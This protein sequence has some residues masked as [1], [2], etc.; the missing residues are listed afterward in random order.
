MLDYRMQIYKI[1]LIMLTMVMLTS[2]AEK[3]TLVSAKKD[4]NVRVVSLIPFQ[5]DTTPLSNILHQQLSVQ[6]GF[7]VLELSDLPK[8]SLHRRNKKSLVNMNIDTAR[9]L[10]VQQIITGK[11]IGPKL[12]QETSD[13]NKTVCVQGNCWLTLV[14]C[15]SNSFYIHVDVSV[16][17]NVQNYK[18]FKVSTEQKKS[19]QEC[20]DDINATRSINAQR[21]IFIDEIA[22]ELTKELVNNLSLSF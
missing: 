19:W 21:K 5:N 22:E 13:H 7:Y 18:P 12:E 20:A 14:T 10:Q 17:P 3:M 16:L 8:K 15:R 1:T 6:P 4:P 9:S 2:C 11:V